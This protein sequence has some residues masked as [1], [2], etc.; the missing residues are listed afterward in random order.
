MLRFQHH[1]D[2]VFTAILHDALEFTS[3]W[4]ADLATEDPDFWMAQYPNLA[5]C[6]TPKAAA[7]A[8]GQL[9][10]ASRESAIYQ[11]TDYHWLLLH[12]CLQV[13]CAIH[14]DYIQQELDRMFPVGPYRIGEIAFNELVDLY[15]WDTDFLAN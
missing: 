2:S 5:R 6:F 10:A 15:F 8:I 7:N 3:G 1:P 11:L 9:L 14:Y 12:E 13:Y 4:V